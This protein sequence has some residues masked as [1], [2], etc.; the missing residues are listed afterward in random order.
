MPQKYTLYL[1]AILNA[2][3]A[4]RDGSRR[5]LRRGCAKQKRIEVAT[6][7]RPRGLGV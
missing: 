7:R 5:G 6:K 2:C 1:A 4:P 3:T